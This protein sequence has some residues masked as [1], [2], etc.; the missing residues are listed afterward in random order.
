MAVA[1]GQLARKEGVDL[2]L[3]GAD[4][5]RID[6]KV[7]G[8]NRFCHVGSIGAVSGAQDLQ[9]QCD[10]ALDQFRLDARID[11][12]LAMRLV[13]RGEF[14]AADGRFLVGRDGGEVDDDDVFHLLYF[15]HQHGANFVAGF[16]ADFFPRLCC[17]FGFGGRCGGS[18]GIGAFGRNVAYR[19]KDDGLCR[20]LWSRAF[21]RLGRWGGLIGRGH[22]IFG[23]HFWGR[24]GGSADGQQDGE[25]DRLG[26][27]LHGVLLV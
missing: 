19:F 5:G 20:F 26:M 21:V 13:G 12:V 3:C 4:V 27:G 10:F 23:R 18:I 14:A 9:G 11:A 8:G 15:I 7:F 6:F 16:F 22:Q 17:A 1:H 24:A 2:F 25:G